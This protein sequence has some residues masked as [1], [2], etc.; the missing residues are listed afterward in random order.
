[1]QCLCSTVFLIGRAFLNVTPSQY[2]VTAVG[3]VFFGERN[4]HG[5]DHI[6]HPHCGV[7]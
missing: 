6:P 4:D 1:V 2:L 3:G 7:P 5:V